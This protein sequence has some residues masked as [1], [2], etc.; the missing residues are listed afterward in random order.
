VTPRGTRAAVVAAVADEVLGLAS[1]EVRRVAVDG[2]DGAGKTVFADELAGE[3]T[4]RQASVIRASVDGFHHPREIRYRRG[5]ASPEGFFRD[6]YDY[7]Q[8][9]ALLLEP[10][11]PGGSGRFVRRI[12]DVEQEAPVPGLVE[13]ADPGAILV[14]DGIFL[15]RDELVGFWDYSV[16]LEV[17]FAVSIPRGARR[18][19]GDPDP[20]SPSNR[21]YVEGQRLYLATCEPQ[22]RATV[23]IDNTDLQHP[24]VR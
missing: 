21:R 4:R 7:A 12:H 16:W 15:H 6:S 1:Q 14:L 20:A 23:V 22:R 11:G 9:I 10:L 5:R 8:L 13:Q 18:G 2:V 3:L 17:P 19:F 24:R